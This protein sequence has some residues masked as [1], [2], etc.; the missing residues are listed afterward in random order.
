MAARCHPPIAAP[1]EEALMSG[2]AA[3]L[4]QHLARH[5]ED[6]CRYYLPKGRRNGRYWLTGDVHD[7][8]GRSL[9]VRIAGPESGPGA[10]GKW[11]DCRPSWCCGR[12]RSTVELLTRLAPQ[13]DEACRMLPS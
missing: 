4:A 12:T 8:P 2:Q 1:H 6:V 13:T 11:T 9:Y 7:T 3:E 10:A 5:A